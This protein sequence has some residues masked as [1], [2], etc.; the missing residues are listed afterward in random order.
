MLN[1]TNIKMGSNTQV[2]QFNT[3]STGMMQRSHPKS[4][5]VRCSLG[6]NMEKWLFSER[7]EQSKIDKA[8]SSYNTVFE[9][10]QVLQILIFG[11]DRYLIEIVKLS[12]LTIEDSDK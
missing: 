5:F 2:V 6:S 1:T 11:N 4:F 8:T 7:G 12:D 10:V 3:T 9:E